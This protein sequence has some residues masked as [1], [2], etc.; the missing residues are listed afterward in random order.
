MKLDVVAVAVLSLALPSV[1]W[2]GE[3]IARYAFD[4]DLSDAIGGPA[5]IATG[6]TPAA[7]RQGRAARAY[8]FAGAGQ[9]VVDNAKLPTGRSPRTLMAWFRTSNPT[10]VEV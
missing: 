1:A 9:I 6:A 10:A 5:G 2:A 8:G 3:P 7:D 4:G